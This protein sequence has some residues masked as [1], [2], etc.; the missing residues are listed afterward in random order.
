MERMIAKLMTMNKTLRILVLEDVQDD[1]VLIEY[2][3]RKDGIQFEMMPVDSQEMFI[4]GLREF[5]KSPIT[6]PAAGRATPGW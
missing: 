3:L 4:R 2:A 1:V 6:A 5:M